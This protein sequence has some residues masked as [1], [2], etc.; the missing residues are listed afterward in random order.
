MQVGF[1]CNPHSILRLM[2]RLY[3]DSLYE[4]YRAEENRDIE[5]FIVVESNGI[6]KYVRMK[7]GV[8]EPHHS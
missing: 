6:K 1:Q 2:I 7:R 4:E 3:L 5:G 8:L